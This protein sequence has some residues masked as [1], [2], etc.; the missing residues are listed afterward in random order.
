MVVRFKPEWRVVGRGKKASWSESRSGAL[1]FLGNRINLFRLR[2]A[3]DPSDR[4]FLQVIC[5]EGIKD[6]KGGA[7]PVGLG[8][9]ANLHSSASSPAVH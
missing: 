6:L 3:R 9:R 1:W 8:R 5:G 4:T 7:S 2:D